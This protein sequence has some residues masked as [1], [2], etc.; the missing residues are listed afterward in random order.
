MFTRNI[1][2]TA[3]TWSTTLKPSWRIAGSEM[4]PG[5]IAAG[6]RRYIFCANRTPFMEQKHPGLNRY[7]R[8]NSGNWIYVAHIDFYSSRT[9][10]R[11]KRQNHAARILLP[12][13]NSFQTDERSFD[14]PYAASRCDAR[15]RL[16]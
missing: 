1:P 10:D 4:A 15:V 2:P 13:Q 5:N 12:N 7:R 14:H 8:R 9:R 6:Q 11:I 3:S 16:D